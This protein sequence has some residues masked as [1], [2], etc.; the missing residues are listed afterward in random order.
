LAIAALATSDNAAFLLINATTTSPPGFGLTQDERA[1]F[2]HLNSNHLTGILLTDDDRLGYLAAA[3]TSTRPWLGHKYNTPNFDD[4]Q[5]KLAAFK[6]TTAAGDLLDEVNL[7]LTAD[8]RVIRRL[9]DNNWQKLSTHGHL[10]LWQ[11][12]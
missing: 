2:A 4:R 1:A 10:Q 9:Q 12:P 11:K 5:T 7:A 8:P 6:S 3:L